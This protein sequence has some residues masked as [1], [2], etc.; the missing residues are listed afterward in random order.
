MNSRADNAKHVETC[1]CTGRTCFFNTFPITATEFIRWL[2]CFSIGLTLLA[3]ISSSA[4]PALA[5]REPRAMATPDRLAPP[6][7][8]DNPTQ[9]DHGAQTYYQ[10]CMACHG[11]R[12]QGL[13]DE[14]RSAWAP[15]DQNCW[16]SRCHAANHPPQGFDLP[17]FA[18]PVIGA[19]TLARFETAG[20][21]NEFICERMPWQAPST[22]DER[23]CWQL[24]AF[25]LRANGISLVNTLLSVDGPAQQQPSRV[26]PDRLAARPPPDFR[27]HLERAGLLAGGL[28]LIIA[29][30]RFT[31]A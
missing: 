9:A 5:Q 20:N 13:T 31:R 7:M 11:D 1:S 23:E 22:L 10:I 28:L 16:Q 30:K 27:L 6:P 14:W 24:T 26:A 3:G 29:L 12:G 8:P 25:L 18:P 21:L 2:A 17:H 15:G 19:G 4:T